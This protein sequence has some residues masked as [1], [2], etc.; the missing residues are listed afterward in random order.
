MITDQISGIE[1]AISS[2]FGLWLL[3][4][5]AVTV[6]GMFDDDYVPDST[7][8]GIFAPNWNFFSPRPG[9]WDFHLLYRDKR[10]DG[11]TTDWTQVREFSRTPDRYKWLWN[12]ASHR[13]KTLFDIQQQLT[14]TFQ[15]LD[16]VEEMEPGD[17]Q[18][19]ETE[20]HIVTTP[21]LQLLNRVSNE[22]HDD[23][24]VQ[25]QFMLMRSTELEQY[26]PAVIFVSNFHEL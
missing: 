10:S 11:S 1:L 17:L 25:T 6:D 19:L 21:Y 13:S 12:T 16:E 4:T 22:T 23:D 9:R 20:E 26:E 8:L 18:E 15:E 3:G 7:V 24:A 14:T 5:A 2:L